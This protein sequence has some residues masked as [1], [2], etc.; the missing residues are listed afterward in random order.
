VTIKVNAPPVVDAGLDVPLPW[1]VPL[2]AG[3]AATDPDGDANDVLVAELE[4][5]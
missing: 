2:D 4:L 3:G 1:G 5:R